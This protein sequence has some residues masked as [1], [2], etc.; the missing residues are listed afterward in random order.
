MPK[1]SRIKREEVEVFVSPPKEIVV[2]TKEINISED[3][4]S[5]KE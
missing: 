3:K 1:L 4:F 5:E 2:P